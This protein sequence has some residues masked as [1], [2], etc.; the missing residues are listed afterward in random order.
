[1]R[2]TVRNLF[3]G[4]VL[5]VGFASLSHAQAPVNNPLLSTKAHGVLK[6]FCYR[7]HGIVFNAKNLNVL[8]L[9]TLFAPRK[10]AKPYVVAGAAS[11]S[12][13]YKRIVAGTMPPE[14]Q[15]QPSDEEKKIIEAWID[16]G[17]PPFPV[18]AVRP[19]K[20]M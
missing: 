11:E 3:A 20:R 9:K 6:T 17:A 13:L 5:W 2:N 18:N 1:M 14:D 7:C 4:M 8:E 12:L 10:D 15:A 16:G 19:F